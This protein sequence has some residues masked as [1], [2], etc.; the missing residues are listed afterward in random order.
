VLVLIVPALYVLNPYFRTLARSTQTPAVASTSPAGQGPYVLAEMDSLAGQYWHRVAGRDTGLPPR[1]N[2]HDEF[3]AAWISQMRANLQ[4]LPIAVASQTFPLPGFVG[5]PAKRPGRNVVVIVPGT[6]DAT[7][8]VVL[9]AHYDGEPS[10]QGSA[11]DD[12]SGCAIMLG[13]ARALGAEWRAHGLPGMTVEFVLFDG[14]EQ[15]LI[16]SQAY[17]Y[18]LTHGAVIPAPIMMLDEEQTGTGYPARPFGNLAR[19]PMPAFA[20]TTTPGFLE[21]I[22][23]PA[24]RAR[25]QAG[26][27]LML[28]RLQAARAAAFASLHS[29]YPTLSSGTT[30]VAAFTSADLKDVQVGPNPICCSDNVPFEKLGLPTETF[31]GDFQYYFTRK[32]DWSYPFDQPQDMPAA[33]ACD[34]EGSPN[35]GVALEATLALPVALSAQV[36]DDYAA[37]H[38][39]TAGLSVM[40]M[41]A[42]AGKPVVLTA[43]GSGQIIWRFGDGKTATGS[44]VEHTYARTGRYTLKIRSTNSRLTTTINVA[45]TRAQ[46]HPWSRAIS[47]PPIIPWHPQELNGV[48]GCP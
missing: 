45:R 24:L 38:P 12:A 27:R 35:P 34:T 28:T 10:S 47:P 33:L 1:V 2:G 20:V 42:T 6:R 4:G 22:Q 39:S 23:P 30:T 7:K 11:F 21:K 8:A 15:G 14:E 46:P 13:I 44:S 29:V 37:S 17:A 40:A 43:A 36:V 31:S 32:P 19:P 48:A 41:P 16:G 18:Y 9:A 26:L 3:A 5:L 25:L